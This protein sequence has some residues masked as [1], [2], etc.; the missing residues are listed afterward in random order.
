MLSRLS[1]PVILGLFVGIV[2]IIVS[3]L[4]FGL[5]LDENVGLDLLFKLRGER[6]APSDVVVV[7]IDKDSSENLNLPNN[8]DKWPRSIHARLIENLIKEGARAIAF[9]V[10][11]IEP[12]STEDDNLFA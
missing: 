8:P 10:H 3:V 11:F 6:Q 12:R 5:N 2:G 7:S 9:D 4:P 1:K